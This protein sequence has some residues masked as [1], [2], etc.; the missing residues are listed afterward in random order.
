MSSGCVVFLSQIHLVGPES[1]LATAIYIW[2]SA[3]SLLCGDHSSGTK[4]LL[5]IKASKSSLSTPSVAFLVGSE[6]FV[7]WLQQSALPTNPTR[8]AKALT[9]IPPGIKFANLAIIPIHRE[10]L[11]TVTGPGAL[12]DGP[13]AF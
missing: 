13:W 8:L 10:T 9:L 2:Y 7:V 4:Q 1:H 12:G 11:A 6:P 3:A 5:P